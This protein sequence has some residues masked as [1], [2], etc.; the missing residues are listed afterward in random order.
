MPATD[1]GSSVSD[2]PLSPR[3]ADFPG[4]CLIVLYKYPSAQLWNCSFMALLEHSVC[5]EHIPGG[6]EKGSI[7][8]DQ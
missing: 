4:K 3:G 5:P 6:M 2:K 7:E 1:A 8:T